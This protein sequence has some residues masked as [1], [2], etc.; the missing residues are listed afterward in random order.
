MR[1]RWQNLAPVAHLR[2]HKVVDLFLCEYTVVHQYFQ[3][4]HCRHC[5]LVALEE[6]TPNVVERRGRNCVNQYDTPAK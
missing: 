5:E 6:S 1:Q 4:E 2:H 3:G